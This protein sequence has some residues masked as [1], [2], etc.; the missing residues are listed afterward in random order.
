[1]PALHRLHLVAVGIVLRAV[2]E[3]YPNQ[4]E[5]CGLAG[6]RGDIDLGTIQTNVEGA[7]LGRDAK[8]HGLLLGHP[9]QGIEQPAGVSGG[10]G[11]A[12]AIWVT[13]GL[14]SLPGVL[15]DIHRDI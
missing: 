14:G 5:P 12:A 1:M 7:L 13:G 3:P 2:T 11:A 15:G 6:R 10:A 8:L 9:G 4:L